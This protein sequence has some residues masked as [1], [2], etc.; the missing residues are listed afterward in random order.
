[1][2]QITPCWIH[3]CSWAVGHPTHVSPHW[4][5]HALLCT[6]FYDVWLCSHMFSNLACF[7]SSLDITQ[8]HVQYLTALFMASVMISQVTRKISSVINYNNNVFFQV[9]V[10]FL[11][12]SFLH[13][14]FIFWFYILDYSGNLLNNLTQFVWQRAWERGGINPKFIV[15]LEVW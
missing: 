5:L 13:I 12:L 7:E 4:E 3:F 15:S 8:V 9:S 10:I 14:V 11:F 6:Y 2:Q 1:M